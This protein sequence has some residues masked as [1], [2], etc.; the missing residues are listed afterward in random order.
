MLPG[1]TFITGACVIIAGGMGA[2]IGGTDDAILQPETPL[3][4]GRFA[5]ISSCSQ[6]ERSFYFAG[7]T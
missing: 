1:G 2:D 7:S 6:M 3:Y 5:R 4:R